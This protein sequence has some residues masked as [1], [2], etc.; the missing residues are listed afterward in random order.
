MVSVHI[1]KS[2]LRLNLYLLHEKAKA[3]FRSTMFSIRSDPKVTDYILKAPSKLSELPARHSGKDARID[4]IRA[5]TRLGD[6][7]TRATAT[8]QF[9]LTI[10][11]NLRHKRRGWD[12]L[13]RGLF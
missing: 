4:K 7:K 8:S 12:G 13:G 9:P 6:R 11:R 5:E 3:T 2:T 10:G 1:L